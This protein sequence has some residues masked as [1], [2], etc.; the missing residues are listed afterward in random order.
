MKDSADIIDFLF[1]VSFY[2]YFNKK[3]VNLLFFWIKKKKKMLYITS[4]VSNFPI[5]KIQKEKKVDKI[6]EKS[7]IQI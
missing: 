7:I 4:N 6:K 5:I 3:E 1:F 2:F